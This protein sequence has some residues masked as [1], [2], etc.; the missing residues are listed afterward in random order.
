[1][2]ANHNM[3]IGKVDATV[4]KTLSNDMGVK[5]FPTLKFRLSG[6]EEWKTYDGGRKAKDLIGFAERMSNKPVAEI[7]TDADFDA[8]IER[9]YNGAEVGFMLGGSASSDLPAPLVSW[10]TEMATANQASAYFSM[11]DRASK[12]KLPENL[13][14][15]LSSY[16]AGAFIAVVEGGEAPRYFNGIDTAEWL[17]E[18]EVNDLL[19]E[20]VKTWLK[21]SNAPIFSELGSH[22]FR[23]LGRMG[24]LLVI[25]IVD[26]EAPGSE[27]YKWGLKAV[28]Q[29]VSQGEEFVPRGGAAKAKVAEPVEGGEGEDG[30]EPYQTDPFEEPLEEMYVYGHLDGIKWKDFIHQFNVYGDLPR[31][32]V[33]DMPGEKFWEDP[34]VDEA[35]E[36]D[37]FLRDVHGG[38]VKAQ[39]EGIQGTWNRLVKKVKS[40][41]PM[42]GLLV[43]PVILLLMAFF[44]SPADEDDEYEPPPATEFKKDN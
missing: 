17:V 28:A 25:G 38:R 8:F 7:K 3:H 27:D 5:G 26:P 16:R 34:T 21:E 11:T 35:D 6:E 2:L 1:M 40:M 36:I 42:S 19:T 33:L 37:T 14:K 39:K 15:H 9:T 18:G 29:A 23:Q 22:N 41:G 24:K 43:V 13:P 4:H 10:W 31:L 32:V 12:L 30:V 20:S 44:M